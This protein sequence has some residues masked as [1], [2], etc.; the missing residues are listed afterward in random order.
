MAFNDQS[1]GLFQGSVFLQRRLLNGA[2]MGGFRPIGDADKF[3]ITSSQTFDDIQE[4]QTGMRLTSAHIPTGTK[5]AAKIN[6]KNVN[7]DNLS[8]AIWGMDTE[9]T[10]GG[11]VTA[12]TQSAWNDGENNNIV[13]LAN[14]GV[15]AE[16]ITLLGYGGSAVVGSLASIAVTSAGTGYTP[17][18]LLALTLAGTPGTGATGFAVTDGSGKVVGAYLTAAGSGYVAP[19]ATI[20]TPG[21]GTGCVLAVNLTGAALAGAG[22]DYTLD[23]VNGAL[24]L[25]PLGT[26]VPAFL[27]PFG[28]SPVGSGQVWIKAAYTFAAYSGKVEA[29][30]TGIQYFTLRLNG[31]NV[32]N[33]MQPV[34]VTGYQFAADM[35]KVLSFIDSKSFNLELDGMLLQDQTRALPTALNPLSQFF[36]ILK[37]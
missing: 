30:T 25:N 12:E 21:A 16:T 8:A 2:P 6:M 33:N 22:V 17:K 24:Q 14:I 28:V 29:F 1:Y 20:T 32:A 7:K 31:I 13:P 5:V 3:E 36:T 23:G 15:S 26:K 10:A 9:D 18:S 11:T 35:A 4:S 19:T 27:D 34:I 37:A